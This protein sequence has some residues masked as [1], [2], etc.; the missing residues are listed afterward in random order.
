MR[1]GQI[2]IENVDDQARHAKHFNHNQFKKYC[3]FG[4]I[5][6]IVYI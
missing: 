4:F 2:D 3:R 5:S 6:N 1:D